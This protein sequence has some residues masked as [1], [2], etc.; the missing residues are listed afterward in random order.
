M[1]SNGKLNVTGAYSKYISKLIKKYGLEKNIEFLG[2]QSGQQMCDNMLSSRVT[3]VPSAI[4]GT[5]LILREAMFLGA[6]V[7][8]SFRGGMAD[9]I[10]DKVDGFLYDYQ[11]YPYLAERIEQIFE[12]DDLC[13]SFSAAAIQK[14]AVAHDREK[15]TADYLQM[16][17][18]ISEISK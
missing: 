14:A 11:E 8:A 18:D 10:S 7:I 15:N 3:V 17:K 16:Y 13:M 9:F 12:S 2:R 5:S 4:E 6:P 1:G